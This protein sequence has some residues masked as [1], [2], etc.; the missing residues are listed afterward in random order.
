MSFLGYKIWIHYYL[1]TLKNSNPAATAD[2]DQ[3]DSCPMC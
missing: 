2:G 1:Q 3:D